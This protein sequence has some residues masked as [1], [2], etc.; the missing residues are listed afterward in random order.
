MLDNMGY[1]PK[2]GTYSSGEK[3]Y[4]ATIARGTWTVVIT[5][6]VSGDKTRSG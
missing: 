2:A 5:F 3:Y 4:V 6:E 1:D